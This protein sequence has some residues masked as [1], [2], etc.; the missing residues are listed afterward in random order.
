M[1]LLRKSI[2]APF[3]DAIRHLAVLRHLPR[4]VDAHE[5]RYV[6]RACVIGVVVW[7]VVFALR[8]A[9]HVTFHTVAHWVDHAPSLLLVFIPLLLG[10]LAMAAIVRY[11]R[12]AQLPYRDD[13]GQ[14]HELIDVEG[15]GLERAI[16]LYYASEP[17][18]EQTL[19]GTEGADVRWQFPTLRLAARKWLG[20]LV[21]LG[22]GGSGGLEASVTLIGE[23]I[24]AGL[25]KPHRVV[26]AASQR[27]GWISRF[28]HWWDASQPD[29]LQ[30]AQLGGVAAAV[31]TLLGTPFAAAFFAMEVMYNR[32]PVVEKLVYSLIPALI[33]FF[34][35]GLFSDH[36]VM[37]SGAT[38]ISEPPQTLWYY[39]ACT[40]VAV[41]VALISIYFIQVRA[42]FE[43]AFH[44]YQP[45]VW[46]RHCMGAILTGAIALLAAWITGHGVEL[47]L[48]PGEAPIRAAL[49][50]D[51]A[52]WVAVVAL[53]AKLFA[54]LATIGSGGSAGLLV[55]SLFFGT[56]VATAL[57][58]VFGYAPATLIIP[59][60]TA[61]LV[62]IVNVPVAAILFTV[63]A[64]GTAYMI[65]ALLTLVVALIIA[66]DA[67]IYRTQREA[68]A[69][70]ELLTG[71]S[72]RRLPVPPHWVG[73]TIIDL[74]IRSRYGVNVIGLVQPA[75]PADTAR[76]H[77]DPD[78]TTPLSDGQILIML[79]ADTAFAA[80]DEAS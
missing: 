55:P 18:F 20:T 32:R 26:R 31:A 70:R 52:I 22:S 45:N 63:E 35:N 75:S 77:F 28:W 53:V 56:M 61:S 72:I 21:T 12:C 62:S 8:E 57:A 4:Y 40:L 74:Q 13:E 36:V 59:A 29:E 60:I 43:D 6:F 11:G 48:G 14:V 33:A 79:G 47:V 73:R 51:L 15:D 23:S 5:R 10:A 24:S 25:F 78:R 80:M 16:A 46:K 68:D 58:P 38:S 27:A 7:A 41:V 34:L 67:H 49:H 9:V 65:P 17:S 19:Q 39:G 37:F 44:H 50:G 42:S 76:T 71:Y 69:R 1:S 30:T 64:F 3:V 2:V 66:H 54:T